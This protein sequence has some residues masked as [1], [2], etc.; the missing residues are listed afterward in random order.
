MGKVYRT[1]GLQDV[2]VHPRRN[3]EGVLAR[4]KFPWGNWLGVSEREKF[5]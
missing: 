5:P 2:P 4:E 3:E 1:G